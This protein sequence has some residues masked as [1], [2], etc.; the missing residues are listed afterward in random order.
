MSDPFSVD[1]NACQIFVSGERTSEIGTSRDR[2]NDQ[3]RFLAGLPVRGSALESYTRDAAWAIYFLTGR[4]IKR[5]IPTRLLRDWVA[6]EANL[7]LWLVEE[8]YDAV[9]DL[10]EALALLLPDPASS[11]QLSLREVARQ[12][13][14]ELKDSPPQLQRSL[15]VQT[16][17]ELDARQR[18]VWHKL[19]TG[20]QI[21]EITYK[22]DDVIVFQP[23]TLHGWINGDAA[24]E[25]LGFDMPV[26][27]K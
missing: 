4:K 2:P 5:A 12:R 8:C 3:A 16:W 9:G 1:D 24:F 13:I 27:R 21:G 10:A 6:A 15:V 14:L 19:I 7:P 23:K 26:L 25:F 11:S 18:L 17:R 22:P 20:E